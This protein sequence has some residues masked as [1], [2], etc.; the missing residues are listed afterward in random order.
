MPTQST[1]GVIRYAHGVPT[2]EG[3]EDRVRGDAMSHPSTQGIWMG[4]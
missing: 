3:K 2:V 4:G 1:Q